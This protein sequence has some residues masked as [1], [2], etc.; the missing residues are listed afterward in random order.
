MAW[1]AKLQSVEKKDGMVYVGVTYVNDDPTIKPIQAAPFGDDLDAD[2]I[3]KLVAY[4]LQSLNC[5]DD[6]FRSFAD[7]NMKAG[8]TI[9]PADIS[10]NPELPK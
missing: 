8:D 10:V 7:A 6:A 2:A 5:C 3:K 4:K 1:S 9:Q